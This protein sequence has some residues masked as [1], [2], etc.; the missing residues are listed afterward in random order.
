MLFF[1]INHVMKE[2][3]EKGKVNEEYI[4]TSSSYGRSCD[5]TLYIST[6]LISL[7]F[8]EW[9]LPLCINNLMLFSEMVNIA[10][11]IQT[12]TKKKGII[13]IRKYNYLV[14]VS[15]HLF[16]ENNP[17]CLIHELM[18]NCIPNKRI[19]RSLLEYKEF[20]EWITLKSYLD[21]SKIDRDAMINVYIAELYQS[22]LVRNVDISSLLEQ[23]RKTIFERVSSIFLH[24]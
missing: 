11:I 7:I 15:K 3:I 4:K 23:K 14:L 5:D 16:L 17:V 20:S 8:F 1:F 24:V 6:E 22:G 2:F 18:Q 10:T 13:P 21:S 12:D 9:G 19:I